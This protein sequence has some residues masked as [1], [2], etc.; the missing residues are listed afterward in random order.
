MTDALTRDYS[1]KMELFGRVSL[2]VMAH[3]RDDHLKNFAFL[4]DENGKWTLAP[5]FDFTYSEGPNGWHTLSVAGEGA[6][7]G[8]ADLL[9]LARDVGLSDKDAQC[10]IE[11]V[12]AAV[13]YL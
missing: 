7:P 6:N 9:R 8:E 2:N 3:N 1:A 13:V 10:I 5:F 11:K 12:R 4:M